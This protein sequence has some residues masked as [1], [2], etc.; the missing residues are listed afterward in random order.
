MA[1]CVAS[2]CK[3]ASGV[4]NSQLPACGPRGITKSPRSSTMRF[5]HEKDVFCNKHV[6]MHFNHHFIQAHEN[7]CSSPC[8]D[9]IAWQREVNLTTER[10]RQNN[11]F[12]AFPEMCFLGSSSTSGPVCVDACNHVRDKGHIDDLRG[13]GSR[14]W[15][16]RWNALAS[17]CWTFCARC[18]SVTL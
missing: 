9:I 3:Y 12:A 7:S 15:T 16:R 5:R 14:D 13:K 8:L 1:G 17:M 11:M 10:Q 4:T 18:D 2:A 6:G